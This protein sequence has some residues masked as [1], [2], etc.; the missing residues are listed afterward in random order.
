MSNAAHVVRE[1]IVVTVKERAELLPQPPDERPLGPREVRG[2]TLATVISAGTELSWAYTGEG[3]QPARPGYAAV[4][5]VEELGAEVKDRQVGD[6]CFCM[7]PHQS[8]QRTDAASAI[9]VPAAVPTPV[10]PLARLMGVSMSTLMTTTARPGD[11]VVVSGLGPVG[12]LAAQVFRVGGYE[13]VAVDPD[14][15]RLAWARQVEI[16]TALPAAPV[17][18]PRYAGRAALVVECSG[19]EAAALAACKLV[20][21]RGEVVLVGVPWRRKT[22]LTAHELLYAVFHRYAVLRSGWE[23]ELPQ[24]AADFRPHSIHGSFATAL[25]W[26]AEGRVRADGLYALVSPREAQAIYQQLLRQ[27][28]PALFQV[29]D[30]E[31]HSPAAS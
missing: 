22:D 25:R 9:P 5:A 30:W 10:A 31:H 26:L 6:R 21:R 7:G 2:R 17:D 28:A 8:W 14:E 3:K 1:A 11:L 24:H 19:H 4:F 18:D 27:Q 13:V 15:R 12:L 29:F 23:W 16:T 20:R